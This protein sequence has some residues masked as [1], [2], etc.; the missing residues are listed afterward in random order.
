MEKPMLTTEEKIVVQEA[1]AAAVLPVS[2]K[3]AKTAET[4]FGRPRAFLGNRF[5]Y[6]VISQRSRGLSIGVNMNPDK[7]CNFD[8]VYCEVNRDTPAGDRA[9]DLKVLTSELEHLLTMTFQKRLREL[10]YFRTV[11]QDLLTLQSVTL[12]GDGEPTLCENFEEIV[13]EVVHTR[14]CRKFPFFKTV[15]ITNASGLYRPEV[16]QGLGHLASEDEIWAKLDAGT[17]QYMDRVNRPKDMTLQQVR[18]N[19]LLIARE[20][21]VVIQSLFPLIAGEE[22]PPEE[23]E[24][25]VRQLRELKVDGAQISLVQIY[26]AHRAPHRLNCAHL[27]LKDL[28]RIAQRVREGTGLAAEVF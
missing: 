12:S 8:C 27:R 4:A 11:P 26:S 23:I 10:P 19:I 18:S 5:V 28:S 9:V 13:R 20:R 25:Y 3:R 6:A 2:S 22:L 14:S 17:Q 24:E 21:P 1:Q 15:L 16:R 7:H